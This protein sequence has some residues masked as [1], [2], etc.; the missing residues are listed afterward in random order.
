MFVNNIIS[1]FLII[2]LKS[3][4]CENEENEIR[5]LFLNVFRT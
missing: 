5:S 2:F 3:E 4:D 1:I